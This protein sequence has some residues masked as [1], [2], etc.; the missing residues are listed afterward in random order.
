[1][2]FNS[3]QIYNFIF[4]CK[5]NECFFHPI[6][7]G[8][9]FLLSAVYLLPYL[10]SALPLR[11]IHTY[12]KS[13]NGAKTRLTPHSLTPHTRTHATR[14]P[15]LVGSRPQTINQTKPLKPLRTDQ[16]AKAQPN[17][18]NQPNRT[19]NYKQTFRII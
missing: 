5:K 1:M 17:Q 4:I 12:I 13:K 15:Y 8:R 11:P 2:F 18:P 9:F 14:P 6:F 16:A 7:W 19:T 3:V 10:C